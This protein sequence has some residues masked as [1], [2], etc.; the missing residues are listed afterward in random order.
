LKIE[1]VGLMEQAR[2]ELAMRDSLEAKAD[3]KAAEICSLEALEFGV[4]TSPL[5]CNLEKVGQGFGNG[6]EVRSA[7]GKGDPIE[8]IDM[9]TASSPIAGK[10][11][12]LES[13]HLMD[14]QTVEKCY[15]ELVARHNVAYHRHVAKVEMKQR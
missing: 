8:G 7:D 2:L 10:P 12:V 13:N 15:C 5:D 6:I 3:L 9:A 14:C 11:L 4:A 1:C